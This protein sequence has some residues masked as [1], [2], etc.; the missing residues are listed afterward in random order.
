MPPTVG[1]ICYPNTK[2]VNKKNNH[3]ILFGKEKKCKHTTGG[4][5]F[6]NIQNIENNIL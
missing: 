2:I 4:G 3:Q 6:R 5:R 1:R